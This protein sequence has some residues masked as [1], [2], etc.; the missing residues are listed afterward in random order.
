MINH[1]YTREKHERL[2]EAVKKFQEVSRPWNRPLASGINYL[3]TIPPAVI[4]V[5]FF[6]KLL[7]RANFIRGFFFG[8][9][10]VAL[11]NFISTLLISSVIFIPRLRG[12]KYFREAL[13]IFP[14]LDGRMAY[15]RLLV[16]RCS[17]IRKKFR[18]DEEG[19]FL[20]Y[21]CIYEEVM[22]EKVREE[23]SSVRLRLRMRH[24]LENLVILLKSLAKIPAIIFRGLKKMNLEFQ[25]KKRKKKVE[26]QEQEKLERSLKVEQMNRYLEENSLPQRLDFRKE[27]E[28]VH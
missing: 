27:N 20:F 2:R 4:S 9:I 8:L 12:R 3:G 13:E 19:M 28:D 16:K 26:A 18:H 21:K 10:S 1:P 25:N 15:A 22:T 5:F 14:E 24:E 23:T 11:F 7:E 6:R 17:E